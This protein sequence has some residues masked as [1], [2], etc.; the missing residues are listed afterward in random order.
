MDMLCTY[1]IKQWQVSPNSI[2]DWKEN[3]TLCYEQ[4]NIVK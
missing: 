4:K 2:K 1:A 3:E